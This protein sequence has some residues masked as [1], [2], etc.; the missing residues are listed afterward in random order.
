MRRKRCKKKWGGSN[1]G[2][3]A[4][5][6]EMERI[7]AIQE[8]G[9]SSVDVLTRFTRNS[10]RDEHRFERL[11]KMIV[12]ILHRLLV[13]QGAGPLPSFSVEPIFL[14]QVEFRCTTSAK[15]AELHKGNENSMK[16]V[17][18]LEDEVFKDQSEELLQ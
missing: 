15:V 3:R 16:F 7:V 2:A 8:Y 12:E 6:A 17:R 13:P 5:Q 14:C 1:H 10:S 11:E 18:L 4:N 9:A